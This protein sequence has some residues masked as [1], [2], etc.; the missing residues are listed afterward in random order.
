MKIDKC[1]C[2]YSAKIVICDEE[3][4]VACTAVNRNGKA[5]TGNQCWVGPKRKT[6]GGAVNTWNK[7]M[8]AVRQMSVIKFK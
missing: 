5:S 8:R 6:E 3:F 7:A 4:K 2:G 1:L